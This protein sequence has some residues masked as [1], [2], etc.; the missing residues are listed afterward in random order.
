MPNTTI[1]WG[2]LGPGNI[3]KKFATGLDSVP[4]AKI[5]A[6]GSRNLK[7]ANEFA[8]AFNIPTA[9][10][11]YEALVADPN[12][13]V[14]YI[15]TP[16]S[17]HKEH[18][19]LCLNAGKHV[20]CEKPFAINTAEASEMIAAARENGLFLME[21]MWSRF[22]P[23]LVKTRTLIADGAIGEVRMVQ[24]DFGFRAGVNPEGRLFNPALGGGALLDVGIY[25][26]SLAHMVLGTP[27]RLTS[28]AH[29]GE[30]GVDEGTAFILG[31]DQ[32]QMAV[33]STA[34]RTNTPHEA[35]IIGTSGWI[36][37]HGPWWASDN[38]TLQINGQEDIISCPI[39]GNGYNYEA[40]EV[41][42][43]IRS[44][45]LESEIMPLDETLAIMRL[46]DEIRAQIGLRYPME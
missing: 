46:M 13:D 41:G 34:I 26:L 23:T 37:I 33:L 7:R 3:S 18:T 44:G 1:A 16:H 9:Y 22:L 43:C 17:F 28:L 24:A 40:E 29:L 31:Y 10:D 6:V 15:G 4:D 19:L 36:K 35:F 38:L 30:T 12:V 27:D 21:A 14:I 39:V 5:M 32:G 20:L 11:S 25:P 8:D 2:I 45:R 42:S